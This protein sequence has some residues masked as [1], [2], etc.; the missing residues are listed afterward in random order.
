[1]LVDAGK[2]IAA[3][4]AEMET[5]KHSLVEQPVNTLEAYLEIVGRYAGIKLAVEALRRAEKDDDDNRT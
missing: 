3:L 5:L 1:M 2:R 4:K